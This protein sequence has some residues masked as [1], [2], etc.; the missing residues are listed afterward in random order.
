[1]GPTSVL[2]SLMSNCQNNLIKVSFKYT[3]VNSIISTLCMIAYA[4]LC[5][6]IKNPNIWY[7]GGAGI[8]GIRDYD[9]GCGNN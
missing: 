5:L 2:N 8:S 6:E 1:M 3:W 4:G 7:G 9:Y